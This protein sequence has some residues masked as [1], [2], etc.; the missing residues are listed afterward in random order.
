MAANHTPTKDRLA[1]SDGDRPIRLPEAI[2]ER[3]RARRVIWIAPRNGRAAA[4]VRAVAG[5]HADAAVAFST[6]RDGVQ[7]LSYPT[8]AKS[9]AAS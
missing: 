1:A 7:P 2:R 4:G 8:L 6:G 5:A 9:V 3:V